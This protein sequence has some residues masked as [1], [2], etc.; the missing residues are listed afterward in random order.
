MKKTLLYAY[1]V[2]L[3]LIGCQSQEE[4]IDNDTPKP[5]I[6]T[7]A[8]D[9]NGAL[10]GHF[11][12]SPTQTVRFSRGLLQYNPQKKEWLFANVQNSLCGQESLDKKVTFDRFG[13]ATSGYNGCS[14]TLNGSHYYDGY[15][16]GTA[17]INGT[18]YDWGQYNAISNGG[19]KPNFWRTLTAGEWSYLLEERPN[20]YEKLGFATVDGYSG[21]V[22]LP[23]DWK[24]PIGCEFQ[25]FAKQDSRTGYLEYVCKEMTYT[26]SE[27]EKME[28]A[29]AVFIFSFWSSVGTWTSTAGKDKSVAYS[30]R[31][32]NNLSFGQKKYEYLRS[33]GRQTN[34]L[35]RLVTNY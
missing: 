30:I 18:D 31:F 1:A 16:N 23:D 24:L 8:Y 3:M 33:V 11:S 9:T 35:V 19:N 25:Q 5:E 26:Q 34:C 27:W 32:D 6:P 2:T 29:G 21:I 14:P 7:T 12:V 13:W 4:P 22:L 10:C 28:Q 20:A 15:Y 17:N